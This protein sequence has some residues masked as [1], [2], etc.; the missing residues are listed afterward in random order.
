VSE[1]INS[2][3]ETTYSQQVIDHAIKWFNEASPPE[4]AEFRRQRIA[5]SLSGDIA[6][7]ILFKEPYGDFTF[8]EPI[9][10]QHKLV[11][12]FI[13]LCQSVRV[14]SQCE[15]YFRRY[16]FSG[17]PISREDHARNICEFYFGQFYMIINRLKEVLNKFKAVC[18]NEAAI[19]GRMIKEFKREFDQEIR[20]RNS[21]VHHEPFDDQDLDRL[22]LTSI[23]SESPD[24]KGKGWDKEYR[25]HYRKFAVT[26]SR[27]AKRR[28]EDVRAFVE[29]LAMVLLK[30]ATF[31][32]R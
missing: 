9:A 17:V 31:L 32:A 8:D 24:L 14:L 2:N 4:F 21:L 20:A 18:P 26:W 12:S 30:H 13:N 16:P 6:R 11:I 1:L 19:A 27:R 3:N 25:N 23:M 7:E 10:T 15:Y 5:Y 29:V 22:F 28:S